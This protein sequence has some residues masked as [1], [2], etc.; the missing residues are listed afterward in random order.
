[1]PGPQGQRVDEI[2]HTLN[3]IMVSRIQRD[4]SDL[5]GGQCDV[6]ETTK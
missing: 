2:E 4:E 5:P 3:A 1:V 6:D